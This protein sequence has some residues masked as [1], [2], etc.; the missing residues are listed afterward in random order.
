MTHLSNFKLKSA[1]DS[2]SHT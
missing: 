1:S 2:I